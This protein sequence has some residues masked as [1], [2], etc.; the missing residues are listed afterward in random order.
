MINISLTSSQSHDLKFAIKLAQDVVLEC[1]RY[2]DNPEGLASF[3]RSLDVIR[4]KIED[5]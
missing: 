3:L 2:S 4:S 5:D 1:E